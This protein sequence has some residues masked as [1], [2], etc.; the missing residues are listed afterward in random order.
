MRIVKRRNSVVRECM[1]EWENA[2]MGKVAKWAVMACVKVWVRADAWACRAVAWEAT[3]KW[4]AA[5]N[6]LA[7]WDVKAKK[8]KT[9][10]SKNTNAETFHVSGRQE[11]K[12]RSIARQLA[13]NT[14]ARQHAAAL[15]TSAL[16]AFGGHIRSFELPAL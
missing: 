14:P 8:M 15:I 3:V 16:S 10:S 9:S 12:A 5:L 2:C 7:I 6:I 11:R 13:D 1:A 4:V